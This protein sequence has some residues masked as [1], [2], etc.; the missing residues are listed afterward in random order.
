[1]WAS[2]GLCQGTKPVGITAYSCTTAAIACRFV[3][4]R[5]ASLSHIDLLC[6]SC[7]FEV[8][9]TGLKMSERLWFA[10]I[11]TG[12]GLKVFA[13]VL[14]SKRSFTWHSLLVMPGGIPSLG[15]FCYLAG[16]SCDGVNF[17]G[18]PK[19]NRRFF[20]RAYARPTS[21]E[22]IIYVIRAVGF[23]AYPC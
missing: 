2:C 10:P 11:S 5:F 21:C 17:V 23:F 4:Q 6:S 7:R 12:E 3:V 16:F 19:A 14:L 18:E 1:M 20:S 22:T 9:D 8:D 13:D 15:L